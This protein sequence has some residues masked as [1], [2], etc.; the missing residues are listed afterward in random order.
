MS[1]TITKEFRL[2]LKRIVASIFDVIIVAII[3]YLTIFILDFLMSGDP[4]IYLKGAIY[5][6]LFCLK[7]L[8]FI[9]ASIGKRILNIEVRTNRK[10]DPKIWI[11]VARNFLFILFPIELILVILTNKSIADRVFKTQLIEILPKEEE[12]IW[13]E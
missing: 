9:N 6:T 11:L 5:I 4:S 1:I 12:D 10:G 3:G 7:D 13:D 8:F 2:K